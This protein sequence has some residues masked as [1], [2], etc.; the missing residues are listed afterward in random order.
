MSDSET[1]EHLCGSPVVETV[2][3]PGGDISGASRLTLSDGRTLVAKHGPRAGTEARMLEALARRGAP[4]PAIVAVEGETFVINYV[5]PSTSMRADHSSAVATAL[6][7]LRDGSCST[8]G[9]DEDYGLRKVDV[10]NP[11]SEDWVEF[12]RDNRLLCGIDELPASLA[13]RV[14]RLAANLREL[15]PSR[16]PVAL[17]HGDLWGGNVVANPDGQIWLIDPCAYH[18]DREVDVAAMTVFDS[19]PRALFEALDLD[20][21]WQQRLPVYRL[22]MWLTHIRLFG[23]GYRAAAERD[24]ESL[25]F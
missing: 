8:Y 3:L 1:L 2:A 18:G 17:V 25:R 12:W 4:V 5:G 10:R 11:R 21:G 22:W 13:S 20:A 23:E 19:P 16:P 14:E 7:Q 24:L 6:L 15:I 9:W